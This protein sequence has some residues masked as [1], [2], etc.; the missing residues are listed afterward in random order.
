MLECKHNIVIG[1][2]NEL[3]VPAVF[4]QGNS[5]VSDESW[6]VSFGGKWVNVAYEN[7]NDQSKPPATFK[8]S[9]TEIYPK[10][11]IQFNN[12]SLIV[13]FG[14]ESF[15]YVRLHKKEEKDNQLFLPLTLIV[16]YYINNLA[17]V[18]EIEE[19]IDLLLVK[20]SV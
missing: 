4:V 18:H 2:V 5:V 3:R 6:Q 10:E 17:P 8:L 16:H 19:Y 11:N 1:V 7:F 9:T 15:G 13:D 12:N 20:T 14:K